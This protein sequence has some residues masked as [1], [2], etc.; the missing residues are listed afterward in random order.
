MA[1]I[2]LLKDVE[3][4]GKEGEVREVADGYARNYLL[5]R[6]L[7]TLATPAALKLLEQIH[8]TARQRETREEAVSHA[9]AERIASAELTI[10]AKVGEQHRLYGSVTAAD[11]AEEL[12]KVLGQPIDRHKIELEEPIRRIGSFEVA[13]RLA[14]GVA[15]VLTVIVEP[16]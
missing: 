13:I 8:Q 11:I 16:E 10:K 7:A 6:G 15:P 3:K 2:V 5:P 9:L 14:H 4:L 1:R 12:E